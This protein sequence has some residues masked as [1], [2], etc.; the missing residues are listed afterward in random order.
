MLNL[1]VFT[2]GGS[3]GNP[4]EAACGV[5]ILGNEKE[6]VSFGEAIGIATNNEAEYRGIL[7]AVLWIEKN[8]KEKI[9]RV[10]FFMDSLLMCQQLKGA[11]K[12]NKPNLKELNEKI[13][14]EITRLKTTVSFSHI[15]REENK[16][17]DG[18][19]NRALDAKIKSF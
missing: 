12:I 15:P 2:D 16:K 1:K 10:D 11:F 5:V 8:I 4:G 18:M 7:F 3:R 9:N 17:A 19:V 13:K 14:I 6:I